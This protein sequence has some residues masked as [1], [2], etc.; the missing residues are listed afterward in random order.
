MNVVQSSSAALERGLRLRLGLMAVLVVLCWWSAF[1]NAVEQ[2]GIPVDT[3][4]QDG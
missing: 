3:A 2:P 4:R 1:G